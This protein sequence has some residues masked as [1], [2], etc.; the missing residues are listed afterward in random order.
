MSRSV[1]APLC[2]DRIVAKQRVLDRFLT[3]P[4]PHR[5]VMRQHLVQAMWRDEAPAT[6]PTPTQP[7]QTDLLTRP[8]DVS[9][10]TLGATLPSIILV[11]QVEMRGKQASSSP[12]GANPATTMQQQH[13]AA[14][15][16]EA[17]RVAEEEARIR[18][19]GGPI[20]AGDGLPS[21]EAARALLLF[22][23]LRHLAL[24]FVGYK[25]V[26]KTVTPTPS[27]RLDPRQRCKR[28][29]PT[30][31]RHPPSLSLMKFSAGRHNAP[32]CMTCLAYTLDRVRSPA[33]IAL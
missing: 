11:R 22:W 31:P 28:G 3:A 24:C 1:F 19:Q 23:A 16:E 6:R 20:Q 9:I 8:V 32:R 2:D 17:M 21:N 10:R 30:P 5:S 18:R 12:Q 13:G 26:N 4:P 15:R 7:F 25:T 14:Q 33:L 29:R 27:C